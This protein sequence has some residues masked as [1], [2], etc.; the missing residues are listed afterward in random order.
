MCCSQKKYPCFHILSTIDSH[1]YEWLC[2]HV[3][4]WLYQCG[5]DLIFE[6]LNLER[7][8]QIW[9]DMIMASLWYWPKFIPQ[10]SSVDIFISLLFVLLL[11]KKTLLPFNKSVMV[12]VC[13]MNIDLIFPHIFIKGQS[14]LFS[15]GGRLYWGELNIRKLTAVRCSAKDSTKNFFFLRFFCRSFSLLADE[16]TNRIWPKANF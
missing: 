15:T 4:R 6:H 16:N 11:R 3:E 14:C 7:H 13:S 8:F 5:F 2:R 1:A 9:I 12:E 10:I